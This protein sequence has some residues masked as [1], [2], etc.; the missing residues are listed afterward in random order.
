M[1]VV[2]GVE[3]RNVALRVSVLACGYNSLECW[4]DACLGEQESGEVEW[5][6]SVGCARRVEEMPARVQLVLQAGVCRLDA[7]PGCC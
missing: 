6:S 1:K 4:G 5:N 3:N 2:R 7:T